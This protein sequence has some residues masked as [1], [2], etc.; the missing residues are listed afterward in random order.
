MSS[1]G[2]PY[3]FGSPCFNSVIE[4]HK[5]PNQQRSETSPPLQ[6]RIIESRAKL[7]ELKEELK[8]QKEHEN[9]LKKRNEE[10]LEIYDISD[11]TLEEFVTFKEKLEEFSRDDMKR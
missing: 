2:R 9:V 11:L 8:H 7:D 6:T 4:R 10:T 3:V 1:N 5:N